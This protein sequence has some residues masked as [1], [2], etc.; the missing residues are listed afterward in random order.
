[1][2]TYRARIVW[3]L[4]L[5]AMVAPIHDAWAGAPTD[6]LRDGINRVFRILRDPDMAGDTKVIQR[7]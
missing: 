2:V 1:M 5:L 6:E 4:I 3:T 7:R